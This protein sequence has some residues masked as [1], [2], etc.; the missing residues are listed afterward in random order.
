MNLPEQ[1]STNYR[2]NGTMRQDSL[3]PAINTEDLESDW[4]LFE[5]IIFAPEPLD[6]NCA[7]KFNLQSTKFTQP[8]SAMA[9]KMRDSLPDATKAKDRAVVEARKKATKDEKKMSSLQQRL[10]R[11]RKAKLD[12][13]N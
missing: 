6:Q 9:P 12:E 5:Q 8:D 1:V 2:I 13:H 4:H 3:L 11:I 10:N 7:S